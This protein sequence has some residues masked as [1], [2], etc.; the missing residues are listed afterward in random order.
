MKRLIYAGVAFVLFLLVYFLSSSSFGTSLDAMG[1]QWATNIDGSLL[2]KD[3]YAISKSGSLL[4]VGC[5]GIFTLWFLYKRNW[6]ILFFYYLANVGGIVFNYILKF[7]IH[8]PRPE[9]IEHSFNLLGIKIISYSFPSGHTMRATILMLSI[10]FI[11]YLYLKNI[12]L[13]NMVM[14]LCITYVGAMGISRILL[15]DH[16]ITDVL[17]AVF[18]SITWIY[19]SIYLLEWAEKKVPLLK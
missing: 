1:M 5:T 13:R 6:K 9:D 4:L 12:R 14:L 11:A 2:E 3:M 19:L 15:M 10:M 16:F 8:R 7:A 18:A 17:A